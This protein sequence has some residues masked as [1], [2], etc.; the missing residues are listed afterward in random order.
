MVGGSN[1]PIL[2]LLE[3]RFGIPDIKLMRLGGVHHLDE[4]RALTITLGGDTGISVHACQLPA[5]M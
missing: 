1:R 2:Q 4:L 3:F 5:M